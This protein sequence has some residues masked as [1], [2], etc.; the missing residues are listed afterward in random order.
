[1]KLK[2]EKTRPKSSIPDDRIKALKRLKR[3]LQAEWR[4]IQDRET[5]IVTYF[6]VRKS[7]GFINSHLFFSNPKVNIEIGAKV[8]FIRNV[9][10]NRPRAIDIT[11]QET[12]VICK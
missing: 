12:E 4:G 1:M 7:Y 5:G 10:G 11:L 8:S 2:A 9:T 3:Q 6:N